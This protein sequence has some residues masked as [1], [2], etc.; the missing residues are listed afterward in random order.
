M[1]FRQF[2]LLYCLLFLIQVHNKAF[3]TSLDVKEL[4]LSGVW[5]MEL[6]DKGIEKGTSILEV[7]ETACKKTW[8]LGEEYPLFM[9]KKQNTL[10]GEVEKVQ[11]LSFFQKP[12]DKKKNYLVF[13]SY[14]FDNLFFEN[15]FLITS[16]HYSN[17]PQNKKIICKDEYSNLEYTFKKLS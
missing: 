9:V 8:S 11:I 17:E 5:A 12:S 16:I 13:Y 3:A 2:H 15:S 1:I 14:K 7:V 10:R 6:K 4:S